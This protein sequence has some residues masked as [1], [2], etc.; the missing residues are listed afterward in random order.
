MKRRHRKHLEGLLEAILEGIGINLAYLQ[1]L[2]EADRDPA[3]GE[4]CTCGCSGGGVSDAED[5]IAGLLPDQVIV[6]ELSPVD[7]PESVKSGGVADAED[8]ET[9]SAPRTGA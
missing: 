3:Q 1:D 9:R 7:T 2:G 6:D 8:E 5:T 4:G